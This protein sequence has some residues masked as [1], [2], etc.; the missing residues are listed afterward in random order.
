MNK[1]I[2]FLGILSLSFLLPSCSATQGARRNIRIYNDAPKTFDYNEYYKEESI[3]DSYDILVNANTVKV[4]DNDIHTPIQYAYIRSGY[5]K[6]SNFGN[7]SNEYSKSRSLRLLA[8][9]VEEEKEEYVIQVSESKKFDESIIYETTSNYIDVKNLK[10]GTTYYI[11]GAETKEELKNSKVY[12]YRTAYSL[13]RNLDVDGITNVRDLGGYRSKLGGRVRQ[14]L[15]FRGGRL[16]VS[17]QN[18]FK[19][20]I[21][22]DGLRELLEVQGVKSEIDLR[23]NDTYY[24][25]SGDKNEFGYINNDSYEDLEYHNFPLNWHLSNMMTGEKQTIGKIFKFLSVKDNYPVYL[26]CNIGTDR[27]GLCSYLLGTLLGISQEELFKDY[28][29]SNLGKINNTRTLDT[30]RNT[31]LGVLESYQ[32][33]NLYL[34]AREYLLSCGLD[35]DEIDNIIRIF[36]DNKAF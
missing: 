25:E 14:G 34:D 22:E 19:S 24:G 20:D 36:V 2:I 1:K 35:D 6:I 15:F 7:G 10:V 26:H 3:K 9:E 16:N 5:N 12:L 17:S 33:D 13:P 32:Q 31:Y 18:T 11:K 23:M 29:F 21:T 8:G 30:V 4:P 27:T 28:L